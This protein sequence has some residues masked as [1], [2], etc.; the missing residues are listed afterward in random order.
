M[1]KNQILHKVGDREE[2]SRVRLSGEIPDPRNPPSGCRF[3]T[4]CPIGP[5]YH[6]ERT[7]CIEVDPHT[8]L[9]EGE[10]MVACHFP[11]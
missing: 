6:P 7:V 9:Q 8:T 1:D 11:Y 5:V 4:R 2:P 10:H 3:R